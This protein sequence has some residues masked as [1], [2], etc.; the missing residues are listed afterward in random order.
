MKTNWNGYADIILISNNLQILEVD[1]HKK[2]L[3]K[4]N[5]KEVDL[6]VLLKGSKLSIGDYFIYENEVKVVFSIKNNW[7][8]TREEVDGTFVFEVL[9]PVR[10]VKIIASTNMFINKT[11]FYTIDK[12]FIYKFIEYYS[13]NFILPKCCNIN[14]NTKVIDNNTFIVVKRI[15]NDFDYEHLFI[16]I[17]KKC[18]ET[19]KSFN[20]TNCKILWRKRMPLVQEQ[21][22]I[23]EKRLIN[24]LY[25]AFKNIRDEKIIT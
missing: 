13:K 1:S 15:R 5:N 23:V 14:M 10:C 20:F 8:E 25:V 22:E 12:S 7:I 24:S 11:M 19:N 9:K 17:T 4:I 16:D 18:K 3:E 21:L 2:L 6:T